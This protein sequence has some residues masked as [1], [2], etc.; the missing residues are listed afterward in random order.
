MVR[1]VEIAAVFVGLAWTGLAGAQSAMPPTAAAERFITVREEGKPP[2]RCKLLKS[3]REPNGVPAFQVQ[4]VDSGELM[5]IVGSGPPAQAGNPRAMSTRIFHWGSGN[6]PPAGSPTPPASASA[7]VPQ[8]ITPP[9]SMPRPTPPAL[10]AQTP[11]PSR[12]SVVSTPPPAPRIVT[13]PIVS[14]VQPAPPVVVPQRPIVQGNPVSLTP[15]GTQI[16]QPRSDRQD[17]APTVA[18]SQPR[19]V[20]SAEGTVAGPTP[21]GGGCPSSCNACG[22]T[23]DPCCQQS[24]VCCT[25]SPMKQSFFSR[26]FHRQCACPAAVCQP[27]P[28][29]APAPNPAAAAAVAAKVAIAP[30]QPRDWRESWGKVEPWNGA[31]QANSSPSV[32]TPTAHMAPPPV[33]LIA[34]QQPDPLKEP[35][36]YRGMAMSCAT[37]QRQDPNGE[38][39]SRR[40]P[41][42]EPSVWGE[43]ARSSHREPDGGERAVGAAAHAVGRP[44]NSVAGQRSQR[45]LDAAEAADRAAPRE[46]EI[47]RFRPRQQQSAAAGRSSGDGGSTARAHAAA[48]PHADGGAADS[49]DAA[50]G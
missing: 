11:N 15:M 39:V 22:K 26:L 49:A 7:M 25:P 13:P 4:A 40:S 20:P 14:T 9:V 38:R 17:A 37:G 34:T 6:K 18:S 48:R 8:R 28:M 29:A 50:D 45:F 47:Q 2:Q 27:G 35:D 5:T 1:S 36:F 16:I 3:W 32:D 33:P 23:C 24:C 43:A 44:S 30:A 46:T 19:L 10:T 42:Q 41:A 31:A 12:P 21:C